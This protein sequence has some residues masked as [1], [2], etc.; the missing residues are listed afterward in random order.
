[1]IGLLLGLGER[2]LGCAPHSGD[3]LTR[4][5]AVDQTQHT[6]ATPHGFVWQALSPRGLGLYGLRQ[7]TG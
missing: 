7:V 1:M 5:K 3:L 4:R 2:F 6:C